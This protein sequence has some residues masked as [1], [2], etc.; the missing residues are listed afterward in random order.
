MSS[1]AA[2]SLQILERSYS[3]NAVEPPALAKQPMTWMGTAVEVAGVPVLIGAGEIEEIVETPPVT[4][5]PGTKPWVMGV[6]S[7]MGGLLPIISG[8]VFFRGRPYAGRVRDFCMVI[9]RPGFH[10]GMTL[11]AVERDVKFPLEERDMD[12]AVDADFT[13]YALGGFHYE[14]RFLT[15]LDI[16]KLVAQSDLANAAVTESEDNEGKTDEYE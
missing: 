10:F 7:H 14:D 13:E 6:A 5:I 3:E 16:D 1:T 2:Q 15:I 4:P 11:S 8:D 9:S 12:Q